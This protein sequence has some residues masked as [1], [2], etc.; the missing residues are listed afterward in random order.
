LL[1]RA[2]RNPQR[3]PDVKFIGPS[4]PLPSKV[5]ERSQYLFL[6]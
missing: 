1:T 2:K 5:T 4:G 3:N 6:E